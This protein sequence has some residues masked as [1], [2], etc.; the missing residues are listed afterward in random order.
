[1]FSDE[2]IKVGSPMTFATDVLS[3]RQAAE[4]RR[5]VRDFAPE[6]LAQ[7]DLEEIL[8]LTGLAPSAFNLQPWRFVVVQSQ[9]VKERL[10]AAAFNQRQVRA[11]PAVIVLYTDT[12]DALANLDEVLHPAMDADARGRARETI[13]RSFARKSPAEVEAWGAEQGNI[14]LGY[15]LLVAEAHGYQTSTMLGFDPAAVKELLELPGHV[16]IPA[17]VAIGRGVDEGFP[18][19]RHPGERIV[20]AA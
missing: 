14:A 10:A 12:R 8:R 16:R 2:T 15:L 1:M 11:A 7:V 6:T 9:E 18:H 13:L 20:R 19:H 17:L 5:S 4:Q 3:V